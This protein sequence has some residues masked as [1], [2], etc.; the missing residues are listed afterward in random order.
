MNDAIIFVELVAEIAFFIIEIGFRR[1]SARRRLF[2]RRGRSRRPRAGDR[3]RED[4]SNDDGAWTSHDR[5]L[6]L[7]IGG[8]PVRA[9]SVPPRAGIAAS[10]FALESECRYPLRMTRS[11]VA[12]HIGSRNPTEGMARLLGRR[13]PLA[14]HVLSCG[15]QLTRR[16]IRDGFRGYAPGMPGHLVATYYDHGP[17]CAWTSEGR[18]L[19]AQ[20]RRDTITLIPDQHDGDWALAGPAEVSHA[21]LTADRLQACA[22]LLAEGRSF[23][24]LDRVGFEDPTTAGLL[25]LLALNGALV[26]P[27]S[28][29]FVDRALDLLSLQLLRNHSSLRL[30]PQTVRRGLA[31]WQVRRVSRY[32]RERLDRSIGL[33]ELAGVVGLS[34]FHFCTA[35]R[36]AT[37]VTPHEWLTGERISHALDLLRDPHLPIGEVAASVGYG[38]ASAFSAAFRRRTGL[39]PSA[40]RRCL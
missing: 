40:Y 17:D 29:V 31:D 9:A 13:P 24:L 39:T 16:W 1:S 5:L 4:C 30:R 7:F 36:R 25:Q 18:R 33:Q 6:N 32:I 14:P 12:G 23:E 35:F 19:A 26:D 37:G 22:A 20:L 8:K 21:Y 38:T 34:R 3:K 15:S 10:L 2:S 11:H 28:R 27:S